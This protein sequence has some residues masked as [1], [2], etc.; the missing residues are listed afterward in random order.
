M[1]DT[2]KNEEEIGK[3]DEQKKTPQEIQWEEDLKKHL[4][5]MKKIGDFIY[6]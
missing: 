1:N 6:K 4:E 3:S 5:E 2:D